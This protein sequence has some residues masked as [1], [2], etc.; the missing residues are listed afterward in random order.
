LSSKRRTL[1]AP[2]AS[3]A[4]GIAPT[5]RQH[6]GLAIRRGME[7]NPEFPAAMAKILLCG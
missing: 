3:A 6:E 7:I 1:S 4:K 2:E 5:A